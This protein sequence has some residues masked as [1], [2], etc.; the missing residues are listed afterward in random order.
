MMDYISNETLFYG[1]LGLAVIAFVAAVIFVV[2]TRLKM[3]R[4][5]EQ[6]TAEYGENLNARTSA[7]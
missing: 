2:A 4:L 7:E 3:S 1:G 6:L 5:K